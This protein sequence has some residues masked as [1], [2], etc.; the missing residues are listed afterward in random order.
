MQVLENIRVALR[1]IKSNM[2][3]TILT[4]LI[5]A[6]GIF[7]LVGILAI[8]DI[9]IN[10][11]NESFSGM[12]ANTFAIERKSTS[13][14]SGGG[15]RVWKVSDP[16]SYRQATEFKEKFEVAGRTA[17]YFYCKG[18]GIAKYKD[19]KTNP[20]IDI[21]G[22]DA[23][24]F[25][26]KD[27]EVIKGRSFSQN[28]ISYGRNTCVI[29]QDVAKRLVGSQLETVVGKEITVDNRKFVVIGLLEK[30]GS[31]MNQEADKVIY[32]PLLTSKVIYGSQRTNYN[33]DVQLS[34]TGIGMDEAISNAIGLF[35]NIRGLRT[36]EENDF[37][38]EKSDAVLGMIKEST[39]SLQFAAIFIGGITLIGAAIGLMN[40][41]LVSVTE[42]TREIGVRKAL[43]ATRRNIRLQF[44]TEAI[45]ICQIGGLVG[46]LFSVLLGLGLTRLMGGVFVM[47]WK[48]VIIGMTICTVV[49]LISGL[50]PALK[51][52][53][54]DPIESLRFE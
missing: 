36:V 4:L 26:V 16:I 25:Q 37:E 8:I 23:D 52:S 1:S 53:K 13:F 7:A 50:Y 21:Y 44:L 40:I 38:I 34:T 46:I 17:L 10:S 51:A 45:V 6:L 29:G 43:G 2:L 15:R 48:W 19:K 54:L 12:G 27:L 49:G 18:R 3:R 35:R 31:S 47:P 14:K 41:M 42:R 20:N 11:M 24:Y 9:M 32:I 33:I 22:V 5:I 39:M 28:E 30:K